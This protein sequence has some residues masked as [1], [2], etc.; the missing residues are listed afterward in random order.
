MHL[1]LTNDDGVFAPGLLALKRGLEPLGHKI[2]IVAPAGNMSAV[3]HRKTMHKPM[4]IDATTLADGTTPAWS[5]SGG[6][7][8]G[9]ALA[10]LGFITEK[11]DLVISGINNNFNL[12]QDMTYSG[13][14]TAAMEGVI[15]GIPSMAVSTQ[16]RKLDEYATAAAWACRVAELCLKRGL[17]QGILLNLNVPVNAQGLKVTRQGRRIYRDAIVVREDPRGRPYYWIGGE[18][19]TGEAV[20]GTDVWAVAH[21]WVSLTPLDLDLTAERLLGE[22]QDFADLA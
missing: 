8:D 19:P 16:A 5:H 11:V 17:P 13:T 14:V 22:L 10:R 15:G 12:A 21:G 18:E 2:T 7:A 4:R 3:G 1:L 6:P 9:V 20:E